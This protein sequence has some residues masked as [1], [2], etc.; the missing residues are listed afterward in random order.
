MKKYYL[1]F[2]CLA[3]IINSCKQPKVQYQLTGIEVD[4]LSN[5]EMKLSEFF[6]DFQIVRLE[7]NEDVL[8]GNISQITYANNK[9]YITDGIALY[10]FNKTGDFLSSI[11]KR[12]QGPGEFVGVSKF[13]VD[14]ENIVIMS[15]TLRKWLIFRESGEFVAEYKLSYF[16]EEIFSLGNHNYILYSG[17]N[18]ENKNKLHIV[19]DD[20]VEIEFMLVNNKKAKYLHYITPYSFFKNKDAVR[21]F[22]PYNDT[23][24]T[25]ANGKIEPAFYI[26]FKGKNIPPSFFNIEHENI[27]KF[28]QSVEQHDYAS[29]VFQFAENENT[30]MF[31]SYYKWSNGKLTFYDAQKKTSQTFSSIH[32]NVFFNSMKISVNDFRYFAGENIIFPVN[33]VTISDW[34]EKY[35]VAEQYKDIIGSVNEDD[36]PVLFI[37]HLK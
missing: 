35:Q 28:A 8:I 7:T 16:P 9:I 6:T 12:G 26:D 32:D 4:A 37:F 20:K 31:S 21:F 17:N 14:G 24:Y 25:I 33:A 18:M 27:M 29:G 34:R 2:L 11:D 3:L 23:I 1:F 36:N 10:I 22:E 30:K 5:G 15:R 19:S 13:T